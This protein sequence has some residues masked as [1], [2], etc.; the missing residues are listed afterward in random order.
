MV[1]DDAGEV[2]V[3]EGL[4]PHILIPCHDHA[5]DPEEE[6][7]R[8]G[9]EGRGGIVVLQLR[10]LR[11]LDRIR[12]DTHRPEPGGEPGV[13]RVLIL[14]QIS[15][16]EGRVDL[17]SLLE[18]HG[19]ALAHDDLPIRQVVGGDAVPPVELTGDIP[20]VDILH[21]VGV[22]ALKLWR[23]QA[24]LVFHHRLIG[25]LDEVVHPEEPLGG[26]LWL[27]RH[28]GPLGEADR[29]VVVL[30]VVHRPDL[31]QLSG[32]SVAHLEAVA[33][34]I[35][36]PKA[37]Q[38]T[39]VIEDIVLRQTIPL[40][41]GVV[42]D[43]VT[44][45]DLEAASTEVYIHVVIHDD[46]DLATHTRHDDMLALEVGVPLVGGID[47]DRRI[48]KDRLRTGR[49]HEDVLLRILHDRIADVV[50]LG[51]LRLMDHLLIGDR[52]LRRRIPIHH[53]DTTVDQ[54]LAIE[55]AEDII[56]RLAPLLVHG[57]GEAIPV[58]GGADLLELADDDPAVLV[59]PVPH[60][61]EEL[62]ASEV[63]LLD[64]LLGQLSHHLRL[65]SYGGVICA[66]DPAGV[67]AG[68]P[69]PADEDI[70]EGVIEHMPHMEHA[71]DVGRGDDD[72]VGR[73]VVRMRGEEL[74]LGP[75]SIPLIL[76]LGGIVLSA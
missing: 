64:P 69:C 9:D 1:A 68:H 28:I 56:H 65:R 48:A 50:E 23:H 11:I 17:V 14:L 12:E 76:H 72:G 47:A 5:G 43:V 66:G 62:L 71:G 57:E 37:I 3:P 33:P 24:H 44:G 15:V 2:D 25:R 20:V 52:S 70:L 7:V 46:R 18:C 67:E 10:I 59:R 39:V 74:M 13:Q 21:P 4:L 22:D 45:G 60:L 49:R 51:V 75:V 55:V 61:V 16:G 54:P 53:S 34:L 31:L 42:V 73:S 8:S 38:R 29:I 6:D 27:D 40:P 36:S 58:A 41:D 26:E 35:L 30:H 32:K 63:A 19:A